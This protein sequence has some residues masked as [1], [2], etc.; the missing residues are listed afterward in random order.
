[1]KAPQ[2]AIVVC[3]GRFFD[4]EKTIF[5]LEQAFP[6]GKG[7]GLVIHGAQSGADIGAHKWARSNSLPSIS[8]HA[9]WT[10]HQRHA[11]PIRNQH[12]AQVLYSLSRCGWVVE[13]IAFPGG[14][15]TRDMI[16]KAEGL[17]IEVRRL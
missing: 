6:R 10:K 9:L 13:L 4:E 3:G 15:G 16:S 8:M 5:G 12:M 17:G 7:I 2:K 14:R 1:M 11:G